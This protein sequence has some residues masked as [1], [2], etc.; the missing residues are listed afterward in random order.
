MGIRERR[1][2]SHTIITI[3]QMRQVAARVCVCVGSVYV[4]LCVGV[5][6]WCVGVIRKGYRRGGGR[7]RRVC[8]ILWRI[9]LLRRNG[10]G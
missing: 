9:G 2:D 4:L 7:V 1:V 10:N 8:G 6:V 3:K 5:C